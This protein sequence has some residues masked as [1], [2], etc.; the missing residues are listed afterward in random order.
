M[1]T[2]TYQI[3]VNGECRATFEADLADAAAPITMGGNA[4]PYQTADCRHSAIRAAEMLDSWCE[5][6]GCALIVD[7]EEYEVVYG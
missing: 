5:S 3:M 7:G 1:A 6:E 4:T 2:T